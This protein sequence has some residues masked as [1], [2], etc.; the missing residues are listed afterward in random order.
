[1]DQNKARLQ[2]E[3]KLQELSIEY[4]SQKDH[5]INDFLSAQENIWRQY[6]KNVGGKPEKKVEP[7]ETK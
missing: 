2:R 4:Q 5:V 6:F 3:A 1:M 7:E